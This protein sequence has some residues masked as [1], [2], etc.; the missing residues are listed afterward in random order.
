MF[1]VSLHYTAP[2]DVV[3][4]LLDRH[5]VWLRKAYADGAFLASGRKEPRT[6]GVIIA[7]GPRA[8]LQARL[9]EDPFSQAGV[10]RYDITEFIPT[11]TVEALAPWRE[12]AAGLDRSS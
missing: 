9:A 2:L 7:V 3:D 10:A 8:D 12:P 4:A 1:I 11:M 6:G 5:V